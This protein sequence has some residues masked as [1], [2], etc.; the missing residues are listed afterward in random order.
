MTQ[1]SRGRASHFCILPSAFCIPGQCTHNHAIPNTRP[2]TVHAPL[3]H[4]R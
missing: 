3:P 4:P 1:P 2:S